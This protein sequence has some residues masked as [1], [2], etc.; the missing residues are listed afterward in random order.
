MTKK[1]LAIDT[2]VRAALQRLRTAALIGVAVLFPRFE[3]WVETV[4][5]A[6]DRSA[7]NFVAA[8]ETAS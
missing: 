2:N 1:K 5:P 3:H 4:P 7:A 6:I 8:R